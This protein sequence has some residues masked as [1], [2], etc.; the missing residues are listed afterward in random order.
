LIHLSGLESITKLL[1]EVDKDQKA[2][3]E[4]LAT[5]FHVYLRYVHHMD[6]TTGDGNGASKDIR[7][8]RM[9]SQKE[10]NKGQVHEEKKHIIILD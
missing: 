6:I 3:M 7:K 5:Q 1:T 8:T 9:V 10:E 2:K 4:G